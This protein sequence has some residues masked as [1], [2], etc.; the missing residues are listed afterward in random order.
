MNIQFLIKNFKEQIF[1][2]KVIK[3]FSFSMRYLPPNRK[4]DL[5][6]QCG[7]IPT[8]NGS[9]KTRN[10]YLGTNYNI[11]SKNWTFFGTFKME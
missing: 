1:V 6:N 2:Q 4:V 3:S 7:L 8:R 11:P 9:Y 10:G 5:V